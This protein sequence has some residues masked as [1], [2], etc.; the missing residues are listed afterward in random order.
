M[1]MQ[2]RE[3]KTQVAVTHN[4]TRGDETQRK[5]VSKE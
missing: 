1:L 4:M 3:D 2:S 5:S